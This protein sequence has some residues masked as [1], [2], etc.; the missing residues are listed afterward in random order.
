MSNLAS[1]DLRALGGE[2][3]LR[4]L[5]ED[6]V[7]YYKSVY[8][9]MTPPRPLALA[10]WFEKAAERPEQNLLALFAGRLKE[11]ISVTPR[12]SLQWK[13][14]IEGPPFLEVHA[15]SVQ[16]FT[17][18]LRD[19]ANDLSRYRVRAE[20]LYFDK[21]LL[22][23]EVLRFFN[24]ITAPPG[25]V[26]GW[27]MEVELYERYAKGEFRLQS[28]MGGRPEL[29][30]LKTEE[31]ADFA[32]AKGLLHIEVNQRWL[33]IS[34]AALGPY[35]WYRDWQSNR[36]GYLL[37]E[38]GSLYQIL[39]FEVLTAPDYPT[40]LQLL[41]KLPDDRYAEVYLR[42]VLPGQRAAT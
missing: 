18:V 37:V 4:A 1:L 25:L 11:E 40:R 2:A 30:L 31:S 24:V 36:P 41:E 7:D 29:G 39:K 26:R 22:T 38:G 15:C 34:P 10:V 42:A 17:E 33:P 32:H 12:Q 3:R 13:T 28:R 27:Y 21:K 14:G 9:Q 6:L 23:D 5:L 8:L 35:A 16:Y 19:R 20:V